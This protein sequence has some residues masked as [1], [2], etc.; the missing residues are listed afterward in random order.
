MQ[1]KIHLTVEV[2][3]DCAGQRLDKVCATCF[4]SYSRARLSAWI[5]SGECTVNGATWRPRDKV[6]GGE[7]IVIDATLLEVVEEAPE[8][9]P[10]DIVFEDDHLLVINKPAGLVVHPAAG[11]RCGTLLNAVLAH[12]P[13]NAQLPRAGIVHRLDK[14]TSGIMVVAK[15]LIAQNAL[16]AQLQDR[17]MHREYVA[18]VNGVL[19]SGGRVEAPIGRSPTNRLKMAVVRNGKAAITDYRIRKKLP[20]HTFLNVRLHSGRTHQIR[21]HMQHINHPIVGDNSYGGRNVL[22]KGVSE[23][24]RQT[25]KA[26]PRQA[27]HAWKLELVHPV[28]QHLETFEIAIADDIL[29]LVEALAI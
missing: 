10:L 16:V 17:S 5:Q 15:S 13:A 24:I 7:T 8:A 11:N 6:S 12:C 4:P 20:A 25:L 1:K 21:V 22:P 9:I 29:A 26:F 14:D 2:S 3:E 27:L 23:E 18:L 19:T 28:T